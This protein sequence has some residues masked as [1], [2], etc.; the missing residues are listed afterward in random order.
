MLLPPRLAKSA[1]VFSAHD[2]VVVMAPEYE[3]A[4]YLRHGLRIQHDDLAAAFAR[5]HGDADYIAQVLRWS[6]FELL[7]VLVEAFEVGFREPA[8]DEPVL[9][10]R[11]GILLCIA[12]FTWK[13]P[14][15][16]CL[17]ATGGGGSPRSH[18]QALRNQRRGR[19]T[20]A[21]GEVERSTAEVGA[22]LDQPSPIPRAKCHLV[23][24]RTNVIQ[25]GLLTIKGA[26]YHKQFIIER[27]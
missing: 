27:F 21:Q 8:V 19:M 11:H 10:F 2:L 15:F 12:D 23:S 9:S 5:L 13:L 1:M 17:L 22:I 14:A 6:E 7:G 4:V 16:P 25:D 20:Y 24:V 18:L 26:L 3:F